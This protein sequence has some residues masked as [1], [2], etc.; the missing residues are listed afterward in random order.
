MAIKS[1]LA[2][3]QDDRKANLKQSIEKLEGC[4]VIE[5]ENKE[6]LIVVT[7]SPDEK[8]DEQLLQQIRN[9]DDLKHISLVSGFNNVEN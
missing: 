7:E 2:F 4:E 1:Y 9:I 5:A 3:P 8:A 6:L